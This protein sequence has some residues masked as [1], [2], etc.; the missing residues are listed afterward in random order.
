MKTL[1]EYLEAQK[2]EFKFRLKFAVPITPDMHD[3]LEVALSK[4]EVKKVGKAKK[5]IIQ[6]RQLDF[7]DQGPGEGYII[8]VVCEYPATREIIRDTVASALRLHASQ[9]VVRTEDEPLETDRTVTQPSGE[10]LLTQEYEKTEK[11]DANADLVAAHKEHKSKKFDFAAKSEVKAS[12]G[13]DFTSVK[14]ASPMGSTKA[15]LP[16]VTSAA[17]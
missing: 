9:V 11:V 8:D 6:G 7:P 1:L 12:S 10:A 17:R 5:T 4:F 13:P 2:K 14:S 16:K 15:K 3:K